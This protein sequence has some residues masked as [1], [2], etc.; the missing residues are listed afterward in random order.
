MQKVTAATPR[1]GHAV[2]PWLALHRGSGIRMSGVCGVGEADRIS[3]C[4][5]RVDAREEA[6]TENAPKPD[7]HIE[8]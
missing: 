1:I 2:Q 4:V 5:W 6:S 7:F 3:A 8:F